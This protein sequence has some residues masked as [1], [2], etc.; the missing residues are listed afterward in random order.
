MR[1]VFDGE[2]DGADRV[3][4]YERGVCSGLQSRMIMLC[5]FSFFFFW[6]I[7]YVVGSKRESGPR[8]ISESESEKL[9]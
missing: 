4:Q 7:D 2:R 3:L 8:K 5:V 6:A 1:V 9:F